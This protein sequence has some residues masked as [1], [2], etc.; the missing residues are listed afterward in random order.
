MN[1]IFTKHYRTIKVHGF[2]SP[3]KFFKKN[4]VNKSFTN[5]FYT[6]TTTS[7]ANMFKSAVNFKL[8]LGRNQLKGYEKKGAHE[9]RFRYQAKPCTIITSYHKS[10]TPDFCKMSLRNDQSMYIKNMTVIY[11]KPALPAHLASLRAGCNVLTNVIAVNFAK[12]VPRSSLINFKSFIPEGYPIESV[13]K[14]FGLLG[15][16]K[17]IPT[18]NLTK[19]L[20][21]R[22]ILFLK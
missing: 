18:T 17:K 4:L 2:G 12:T 7:N 8:Q 13:N 3:L 11:Y 20:P 16:I 19:M 9:D 21:R 10:S 5:S 6:V 14:G 22:R 1:R 15:H